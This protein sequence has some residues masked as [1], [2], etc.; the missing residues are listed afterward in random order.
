MD[1]KSEIAELK[2]QVE[3]LGKVVKGLERILKLNE[4]EI[5]N[6]EEIIQMYEQ[7]SEFARQEL[8]D[9]RESVQA[10]ESVS[11]LSSEELKAAFHRIGELDEANK[12]L[13]QEVVKLKS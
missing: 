12:K 13:K 5:A 4:Q 1:E 7:I 9:A 3:T 10:S 6:A 2:K 8:K 11:V